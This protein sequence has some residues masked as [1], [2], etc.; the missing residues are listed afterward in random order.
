MHAGLTLYR[1]DRST[2]E[3]RTRLDEI[4]AFGVRGR[5]ERHELLVPGAGRHLIAKALSGL[6]GTIERAEPIRRHLQ[7]GLELAQC[8]PRLVEIE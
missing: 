3:E 6:G 5:A 4:W 2:H 1:A 8:L 7:L